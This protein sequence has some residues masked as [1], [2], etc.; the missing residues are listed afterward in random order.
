MATALCTLMKL[1]CKER[2]EGGDV[3]Y[4]MSWYVVGL[5]DSEISP[6][7]GSLSE[8]SRGGDHQSLQC[9]CMCS[10]AVWPWA[11]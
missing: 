4:K 1:Q 3:R 11:N 9:H 2:V 7:L 5:L 8:Q 10:L 6:F